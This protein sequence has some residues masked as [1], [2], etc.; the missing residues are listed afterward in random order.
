MLVLPLFSGSCK[1]YP[2][3]MSQVLT[4]TSPGLSNAWH[5]VL[6]VS[7]LGNEPV[8]VELLGEPWVVTRLNGDITAFL[9]K[10]PHRN[11]RLSE[12]KVVNNSLQCPYHGWE[13]DGTGRCGFI[14]AL[15][16]DATI[17]PTAHLQARHVQVM[18]DHIWIC[19]G[20]PA[21]DI[22][23]VPEWVDPSLAHVWMP[24]VDLKASAAQF[25]DNFLDFGHFPF[26]HAG[27]F[28]SG[29]DEH[30]VDYEVQRSDNGYGFRVDYPHTIENNEDPLVKTGEHPLVQP[31][32]MTYVYGAPFTTILRLELPLTGVVNAILTF[33]QPI[34]DNHSRLYTVMLRNDCPTPELAQEAIDYEFAVLQEDIKI[35]DYLYDHKIPLEAGQAHTRADKNTIEF[36]RIMTKLLLTAKG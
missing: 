14:P 3:Y 27:T 1:N 33:V 6:H 22:L 24:P 4:N 9:D 20:T 8:R 23:E 16:K 19:V 30:I 18:Y 12:G 25:M 29:E 11:A 5:P 36:R 21:C 32:N 35:I 13:F 28:G 15:G 2:E 34:N 7:D 26:V 17:P 10:C 31:R